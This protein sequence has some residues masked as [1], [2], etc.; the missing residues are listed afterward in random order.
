M[1]TCR[2]TREPTLLCERNWTGQLS[3][4]SYSASSVTCVDVSCVCQLKVLESTYCLNAIIKLYTAVIELIKREHGMF[5]NKNAVRNH[6][7]IHIYA[8]MS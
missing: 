4:T 8:N 2:L 5:Q 6:Q 3:V 1:L 7:T